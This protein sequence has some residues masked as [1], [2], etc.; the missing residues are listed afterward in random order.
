MGKHAKISTPIYAHGLENV[1]IGN[2]FE[3]GE[4]LKLRTFS[5]WNGETFT[6]KITIGNNVCVQSDCHIS[7]IDSV[8]IGDDVLIASF[9][10]ISDHQHGLRDYSDVKTAP[11]KRMLSSKGSIK[12]GDKVWIGEKVVVLPGVTIGE[13]SIVGAGSVVTKDI[14]SYSI[15]CGNPAKVI[16]AI[17][18]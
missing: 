16:K 11:I 9:V 12:I 14:P 15:A 3:C 13:C 8:E 10:Y 18:K 6:P 2:N 7:A 17:E 4:R 1:F 5:N